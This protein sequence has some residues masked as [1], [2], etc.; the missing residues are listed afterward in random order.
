MALSRGYRLGTINADQLNELLRKRYAD[1][2][3][4]HLIIIVL[5][6]VVS[7]DTPPLKSEL[8]YIERLAEAWEIDLNQLFSLVDGNPFEILVATLELVTRCLSDVDQRNVLEFSIKA[9]LVDGDLNYDEQ[10]LLRLICDAANIAPEEFA[11][12]YHKV[13]DTQLPALGD[14]S[15]NSYYFQ[16]N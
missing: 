8:H 14:P 15:S 5:W 6:V 3:A 9:S 13:T 11:S 10:M 4:P 7:F 16:M 1:Y 2:E 12:I